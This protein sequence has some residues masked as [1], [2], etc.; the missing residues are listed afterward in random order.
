[1]TYPQNCVFVRASA[2]DPFYLVR[3]LTRITQNCL[4]RPKSR[5]VYKDQPPKS[6]TTPVPIIKVH[7]QNDI[8][9]HIALKVI[10]YYVQQLSTISPKEDI[11]LEIFLTSGLD[12]II[13]LI[14]SSA[15]INIK[16][17]PR[18]WLSPSHPKY[19][20][21]YRDF[22]CSYNRCVCPIEKKICTTTQQ[23]YPYMCVSLSSLSSISPQY[24]QNFLS[25]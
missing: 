4:Y 10:A 22:W 6:G 19:I 1:M 2:V 9:S 20:P 17:N 15:D 12:V 16:Q 13:Y 14:C 7:I 25:L 3:T 23:N 18:K 11:T 21:T 24:S 8:I 5:S